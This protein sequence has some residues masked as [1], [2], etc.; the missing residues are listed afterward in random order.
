MAGN[1]QV[2]DGF[3]PSIQDQLDMNPFAIVIK[4]AAVKTRNGGYGM[5]A[6]HTTKEGQ[7][8]SP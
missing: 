1:Y 2:G 8:L 4:S 5:V 6:V 7:D 3:G